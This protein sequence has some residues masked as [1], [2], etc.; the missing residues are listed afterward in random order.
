MMRTYFYFVFVVLFASVLGDSSSDDILIHRRVIGGYVAQKGEF[1]YQAILREKNN[2]NQFCGGTIISDKWILTA[3]HCIVD[4]TNI[5]NLLHSPEEIEVV[6]GSNS[7]ESENMVYS[8]EKLIPHKGF[9]KKT[10]LSS[11]TL[12]W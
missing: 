8:V 9:G 11:M 7:V 1:P 6:V 10:T 2:G 5:P 3:G 4:E 12:L